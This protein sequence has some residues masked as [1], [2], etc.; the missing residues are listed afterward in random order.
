M[1]LRRI[2]KHVTDQNWF[3]V[4]VDFLI[5]VVGVFIGIQVANWN[6]ERAEFKKETQ[7]LVELRKEIQGSINSIQAKSDAF[8]QVADAGKRSIAFI[9]SQTECAEACWDLLVDFM[10]ASQWQDI[11]ESD[12]IYQN[13][14]TQ[15]FPKSIAITDAVEA[16]LKQ[17]KNNSAAYKELPIYRSLV[18]QI[19]NVKAQEFYWANCWSFIDG[20]ERYILDCP[21][22]MTTKEAN[23]LVKQIVNNPNIKLHLTEW[24]GAIVSWPKTLG[25]QNIEAQKAVDLINKEIEAR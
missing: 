12:A 14:R 10:H 19:V 20:V 1:L 24:I 9:D 16:Y 21:P 3:A 11:K 5:V 22:G 2:T 23:L 8:K 25:D 7:A 13:M 18:R 17:N 15:G 4:F 6:A